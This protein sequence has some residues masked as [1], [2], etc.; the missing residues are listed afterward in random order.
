MG[1]E[2]QLDVSRHHALARHDQDDACHNPE[3]EEDDER[4]A[5]RDTAR[6]S[7]ANAEHGDEPDRKWIQSLQEIVQLVAGIEIFHKKRCAGS[8]Q[9]IA[10]QDQANAHDA[11]EN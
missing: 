5:N 2:R 6:A 7:E 9:R 11:A 1:A 10:Q 3:S 4:L 8:G